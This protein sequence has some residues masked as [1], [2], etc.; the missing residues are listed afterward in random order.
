[1]TT[2]APDE[3]VA[4][5]SPEATAEEKRQ[6]YQAG[7]GLPATEEFGVAEGGKETATAKGDPAKPEKPEPFTEEENETVEA[8]LFCRQLYIGL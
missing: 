2:R 3:P 4:P 6:N 7:K 1:M 8:G 5:K